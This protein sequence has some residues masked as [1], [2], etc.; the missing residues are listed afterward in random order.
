MLRSFVQVSEIILALG[1][2]VSFEW[3]RFCAGWALPELTK[4]IN[5]HQ[6]FSVTCDGCMLGVAFKGKP[7][8]K[9]WRIVTSSK[10]LAETLSQYQCNHEQGGH[11]PIQGSATRQSGFYPPKMARVI[12]ESIFPHITWKYISSMPCRPLPVSSQEHRQPHAL[13]CLPID[14]AMYEAEVD[15]V[16]VLAKFTNSWIAKSGLVIQVLLQLSNQKKQGSL[17]KA[18]GRKTVSFPMKNS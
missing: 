18:H 13:P 12:L 2:D 9:P 16:P 6:L 5:R 8:K 17:Q 10:R 11:T 3:P 15:Q 7:C 4:W 1:G 14:L